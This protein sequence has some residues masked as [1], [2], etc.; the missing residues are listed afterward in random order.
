MS[1]A[2]ETRVAAVLGPQWSRYAK[3]VV[4]SLKA[5]EAPESVWVSLL[6]NFDEK[7]FKEFMISIKEHYT[8]DGRRNEERYLQSAKDKLAALPLFQGLNN[9]E[10]MKALSAKLRP[11]TAMWGERVISKGEIGDRMYFIAD[12]MCDVLLDPRKPPIARLKIGEYFGEAALMS[13]LPR[14]ATIC[15]TQGNAEFYVLSKAD[16]FATMRNFP[17]LE[18]KIRQHMMERETMRRVAE[19]LVTVPLFSGV[20]DKKF[21]EELAS[22]LR[23]RKMHMGHDVV[24]KGH[25]GDEMYF[26]ADGRVEVFL[27][28][29]EPIAEL[30]SGD[31]FGEAA[32]MSAE[33][34]TATVRAVTEGQLYVLTKE[35]LFSTLAKFPGLEEAIREHMT[36]RQ[37]MR[38]VAEKLVTVPLFSG[39]DDKKFMEELASK[40]RPRKMYMGHDVVTKGH[41]GDEMYFLADGRV[42][43]FLDKSEPIAELQSGDFFGEAALMSAEPRTATVRAVTEGQLYVLTKE[44]LFSTLAK[45]PGLEEAIREHMKQRRV[46]RSRSE[47][48]PVISPVQSLN[49]SI[50]SS[51]PTTDG[52][53]DQTSGQLQLRNSLD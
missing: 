45:F 47:G 27:D 48:S 43:V 49:S 1:S 16:L 21:M 10:F 18:D 29:S 17:G 41:V 23:P 44:D 33:P 3:A 12:G 5:S 53:G 20:D 6:Q 31:F 32:L 37:A 52:M 30:Q 25:V 34:R 28:K 42:E 11:K 9:P 35:D 13:D 8:E 7:T 46:N 50:A 4:A 39:V 51:T 36:H 15:V 22:K 19:K 24:T 38:R 26:L 14:T 40:L 2:A